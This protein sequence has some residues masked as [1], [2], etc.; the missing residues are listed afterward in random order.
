MATSGFRLINPWAA[1]LANG[2]ASPQLLHH[3][4]ADKLSSAICAHQPVNPL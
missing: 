1:L 3:G 4:A 2:F